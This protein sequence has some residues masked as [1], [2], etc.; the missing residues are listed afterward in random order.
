[1]TINTQWM[2]IL[3][4]HATEAFSSTPQNDIQCTFI[5]GQIKLM[6]SESITHWHDFLFSQFVSVIARHFNEYGAKT[7]ILSFDDRDNVPIAKSITQCKRRKNVNIVE[8]TENQSLPNEIPSPWIEFIMNPIFKHKVIEYICVNVPRL[9]KPPDG[10]RLIIDWQH[11]SATQYN[12]EDDGV[13]ES[14]V[15]KDAI[16]ESDL[17]FPMWMKKLKQ[18]MLVEATDG[19]YIPLA[20]SLRLHDITNAITILKSRSRTGVYEFIDVTRLHDKITAL[21]PVCP[22]STLSSREST[23]QQQQSVRVFIVFLGLCGTDFSRPVSL[24]GPQ[25]IFESRHY[26]TQLLA[27]AFQSD[28]ANDSLNPR[29]ARAFFTR[30]YALFFP[31]HFSATSSRSLADQ[32]AESSLGPRNKS[33]V[34]SD[35]T[36]DAMFRNINFLLEYWLRHTVPPAASLREYGFSLDETTKKVSWGDD[37]SGYEPSSAK[38]TCPSAHSAS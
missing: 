3:R 8:F 2:K 9:I 30:F 34:P 29:F 25:R 35:G 31:K 24:V 15:P 28:T 6:K 17:K 16:G 11:T 20:L 1:M 32:A 27:H 10:T 33:L 38:R 5:D 23:W 26:I 7:V 14:V 21:F 18:P 12:Y 22:A 13:H 19:D 36:V 4:A 37:V